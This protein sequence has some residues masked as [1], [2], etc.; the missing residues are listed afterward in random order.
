MAH[1][2]PSPFLLH[3]IGV[4]KH[5]VRC[6]GDDRIATL[7]SVLVAL[8]RLGRRVT[9]PSNQLPDR[10][11]L[12]GGKRPSDVTESYRCD[13]GVGRLKLVP[14]H[15]MAAHPVITAEELVDAL[16]HAPPATPND[17]TILPAGRRID[18][19]ESALAWLVE[20]DATR[21]ASSDPTF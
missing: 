18:S 7:G 13:G 9:E 4:K 16:R 12:L 20:F 3:R 14:W 6:C 21:H 5:L 15:L 2:A 19:R 1:L 17:V 10:R 8:R 11:L